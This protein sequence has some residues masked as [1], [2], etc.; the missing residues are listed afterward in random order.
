MAEHKDAGLGAGEIAFLE[1]AKLR[2]F[3]EETYTLL[4]TK[5]MN[6]TLLMMSYKKG[7]FGRYGK[8]LPYKKQT[9]IKNRTIHTLKST[10]KEKSHWYD[11]RISYIDSDYFTDYKTVYFKNGKVIKEVYRHWVQLPNTSEAK[12]KMWY[13]WYSKDISTGYEMLTYIP[14]KLFKINQKVK[15]SFWSSKTLEKIKR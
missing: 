15:K 14:Q 6:V 1:D 4:E 11:Y 7:E 8:N 9:H 12:A 5:K 2:R 3:N 10:Y 13:Y